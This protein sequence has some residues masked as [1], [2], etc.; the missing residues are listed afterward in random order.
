MVIFLWERVNK[1]M[2]LYGLHY[3]LLP[4]YVS[5]NNTSLYFLGFSLSVKTPYIT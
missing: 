4:I 3:T 2:H 5:T 1:C